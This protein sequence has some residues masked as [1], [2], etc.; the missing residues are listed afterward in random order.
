MELPDY[1]PI[2]FLNQ[3]EYCERR[4][5]YMFVESEMEEN[6]YVLEGTLQHERAHAAG[7][8]T[9][10]DVHTTQRRVYIYSDRLKL[11]GFT[12]LLEERDGVLTPVEYKHGKLGKWLNDHVQLCAQALCL[13]ERTGRSIPTG[14]IFYFGGRHR[15]RVELTPELRTRT[16]AAVWRAFALLAADVRPPPTTVKARC[17]DCSLQPICL[18]EEVA[19]LQGASR[20]G[21]RSTDIAADKSGDRGHNQKRGAQ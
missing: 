3:L 18:P 5:W 8:E 2:S 14:E 17:H 11:A 9:A 13:E 21:A 7:H 6:A 4:F 19:L 1:L 10:D 20:P 12:D 15:M 16:E